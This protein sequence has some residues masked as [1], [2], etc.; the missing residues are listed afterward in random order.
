MICYRHMKNSNYDPSISTKVNLSRVLDELLMD[1][2]EYSVVKSFLDSHKD[3]I[4]NIF[5][6]SAF[7]YNM[8]SMTC[9]PTALD[10]GF[11]IQNLDK[12][13]IVDRYFAVLEMINVGINEGRG[14]G[15]TKMLVDASRL[16][17]DSPDGPISSD[18]WNGSRYDHVIANYDVSVVDFL[19]GL[20]DERDVSHF[21]HESV[22]VRS[23][24]LARNFLA[25][26]TSTQFV[27]LKSI[28][29]F[30]DYLY[31]RTGSYGSVL[32]SKQLSFVSHMVVS[33]LKQLL[34]LENEGMFNWVVK[35]LED[36]GFF[37]GFH[38]TFHLR[39]LVPLSILD[40]IDD[41]NVTFPEIVF[42]MNM[43]ETQ[44]DT[45]DLFLFIY[46]A[47]EKTM[48]EMAQNA[49]LVEFFNLPFDWNLLDK[50]RTGGV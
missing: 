25:L 37:N 29:R 31:R 40:A 30:I 1:G 26:K 8:F 17:D 33:L 38:S 9:H 47:H 24:F 35:V 48:S 6:H 2:T 20:S 28:S 45:M 13:P 36:V 50:F 22:F 27:V 11:L 18:Q 16:K 15:F 23:V 42:Q 12:L 41:S 4:Q 39:N 46:L 44:F 43:M 3:Q 10:D 21:I 19:N 32:R 34:L 49:D 14:R 5:T 7:A